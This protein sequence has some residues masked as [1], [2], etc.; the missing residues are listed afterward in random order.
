MVEKKLILAVTDEE[1]KAAI[2]AKANEY[3]ELY[4]G[5]KLV[6]VTELSGSFIFLADFIRE[7][8]LD[9]SIKFVAFEKGIDKKDMTLDLETKTSLK[10]QNVLLLVDVFNKGNALS[11]L[12]NI[13]KEGEA[14]DVRV[15]ALTNRKNESKNMEIPV[16]SLFEMNSDKIVGYGLADNESFRGLKHLYYLGDVEDEQ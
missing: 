1:I 3:Q 8:P 13:V 9:V 12:Y 4:K 11:K 14:K 16:E 10:D 7:L 5:Q 2:V 6:I 15:L